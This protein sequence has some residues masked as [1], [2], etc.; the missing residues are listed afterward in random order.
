[1]YARVRGSCAGAP[2]WPRLRRPVQNDDGQHMSD[3]VGYADY[4]YTR[5]QPPLQGDQQNPAPAPAAVTPAPPAGGAQHAHRRPPSGDDDMRERGLEDIQTAVDRD[6]AGQSDEVIKK[7]P[8]D[9]LLDGLQSS[10]GGSGPDITTV[11]A[12][13]VSPAAVGAGTLP[14]RGVVIAPGLTPSMHMKGDNAGS[15]SPVSTPKPPADSLD[16]AAAAAAT[17]AAAAAARTAAPQAHSSDS[18]QSWSSDAACE[19]FSEASVD[20][21]ESAQAATY[22]NDPLALAERVCFHI[23]SLE[24]EHQQR[25]NGEY[26]QLGTSNGRPKFGKVGGTG[27]VVF[28]DSARRPR[29]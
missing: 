15:G 28:F 23:T 6:K 3:L 26:V 11:L 2:G 12:G 22:V 8:P 24:S 29:R 17:A 14:V 4:M 19:S 20:P 13:G 21:E 9:L 10:S 16:A 7:S 1:M 18:E 5:Q 25:W 27:E